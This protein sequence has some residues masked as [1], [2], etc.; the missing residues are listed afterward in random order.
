M[1]VAAAHF[2]LQCGKLFK[3]VSQLVS[4]SSTVVSVDLDEAAERLWGKH[5]VQFSSYYASSVKNSHLNA[6]HIV[7]TR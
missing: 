1:N 2:I 7:K 6:L 5:S 4:L 3:N